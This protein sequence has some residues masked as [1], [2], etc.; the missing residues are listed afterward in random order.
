MYKNQKPLTIFIDMDGVV[1][2][3]EGAMALH[4]LNGQKDFRPD[5]K[6]DFLQF[7]PMDGALDAIDQLQN[8]GHEVFFASTAPWS[9]PD[10]WKAKRLWVEKHFPSMWKRIFLTHR[11]DLL[12]G[13][14]LIDDRTANGAGDFKGKFI[15]FDNWVDTLN[16]ITVADHDEACCDNDNP[17]ECGMEGKSLFSKL[18]Q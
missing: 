16:K 3:F 11:K 8:M 5:L 1:A 14:I 2:D 17:C 18:K 12:M 4:P 7:E 9:N 15:L 10:A 13:D 6:L